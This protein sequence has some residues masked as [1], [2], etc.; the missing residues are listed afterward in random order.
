MKLGLSEDCTQYIKYEID[1][2]CREVSDSLKKCI[3][4]PAPRVHFARTTSASGTGDSNNN[5]RTEL[6]AT[7]GGL[8]R[9]KSLTSADALRPSVSNHS[10]LGTFPLEIN[11]DIQQAIKG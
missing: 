1:N 8:K 5:I 2:Y 4:K 6:K 10:D 7:P 9:S 3:F 11:T